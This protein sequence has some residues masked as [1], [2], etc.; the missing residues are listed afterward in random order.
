MHLDKKK[1][2]F[3]EPMKKFLKGV[4][5]LVITTALII[6]ATI[7]H[8]QLE[9]DYLLKQLH[10]VK[11]EVITKIISDANGNFY[12]SGYFD[13]PA[14]QT[15]WLILENEE[16]YYEDSFFIKYD[17]EG[18]IKLSKSI[19]GYAS[20]IITGMSVDNSGNI[21]VAGYTYSHTIYVDS[22]AIS[23]GGERDNAF[24]F[25]FDSFGNLQWSDFRKS[26]NA[27]RNIDIATGNSDFVYMLSQSEQNED[28]VPIVYS[29]S[30][31]SSTFNDLEMYISKYSVTGEM[32]WTKQ[33]KALGYD[34]PFKI[35]V[36]RYDNVYVCGIIHFSNIFLDGVKI[37]Q[38]AQPSD[39]IFIIKLDADGNFITSNSISGVCSKELYSFSFDSKENILISLDAT[40]DTILVGDESMF[41]GDSYINNAICKF[42]NNLDLQWFQPIPYWEAEIT[43]NFNDS[44]ITFGRILFPTVIVEDTITSTNEDIVIVKNDNEGIPQSTIKL[45]G[46]G[47]DFITSSYADNYGNIYFAA[48][49]LGSTF[50]C[51]SDTLYNN[52]SELDYGEAYFIKLGNCPAFHE[53]I[54]CINN[55]LIAPN[56]NQFQWYKDGEIIEGATLSAYTPTAS[57]NYGVQLEL[58]NNCQSYLSYDFVQNNSNVKDLLI[59]PN[60]T[61]GQFTLI[62]PEVINEITIY[63]TEG[64]IVYSEKVTSNNVFYFEMNLPGFYIV[65]INGN[66]NLLTKLIVF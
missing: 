21:Y 47:N 50:I 51:N 54:N 49:F 35:L 60:P 44:I 42:D 6:S 59:Y 43:S 53:E 8:A 11:S 30:V 32:I 31:F 56:A 64:A 22:I 39:N 16:S 62:S 9:A 41:I 55:M 61:N 18:N 5:K 38:V 65:Q 20:E 7:I 52:Q 48:Q 19:R 1:F 13:G 12:I 33:L 26:I 27:E 23:L 40:G 36:D 25:M 46:S 24:L 37:Y 28:D 3:I 34:K 63:N 14:I 17:S 58:S 45:G 2:T 29:D 66:N 10:G 15:D 57:G 4:I